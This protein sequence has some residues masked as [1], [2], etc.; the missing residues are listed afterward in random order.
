ML[1]FSHA[2][3]KYTLSYWTLVS[4]RMPHMHT[5]VKSAWQSKSPGSTHESKSFKMN[6]TPGA[7][8]FS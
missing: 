8:A 2:W 3:P 5:V 1:V 4:T 7:L 6:S